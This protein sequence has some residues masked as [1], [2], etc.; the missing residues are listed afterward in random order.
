MDQTAAQAAP[1]SGWA[2]GA[3]AA[4][5]GVALALGHAPFNFPWSSLVA[6]PALFTLWTMALDIR[7]AAWIG[8]CGGVGYF[9]LSLTW[10]VEPFLVD[11]ARHG[12]MAPFALVLMAGGLAL[13]WAVG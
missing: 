7:R 2:H 4:L 11:I 1:R 5:A 10:I 13:F 9:G 8:W 6:L 12:W 3:L